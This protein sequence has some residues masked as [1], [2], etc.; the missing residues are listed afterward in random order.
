[1][2]LS[3]PCHVSSQSCGVQFAIVQVGAVKIGSVSTG[4]RAEYS[5][6]DQ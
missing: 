1:M 2:R 5:A 3:A 4:L 6:R